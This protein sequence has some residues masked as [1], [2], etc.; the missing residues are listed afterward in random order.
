MFRHKLYLLFLLLLAACGGNDTAPAEGRET[1]TTAVADTADITLVLMPTID[2]LP[3]YKAAREGLFGRQGVKVRLLTAMSQ[4]DCDT[5][6]IGRTRAV[7]LMDSLR[8]AY[9]QRTGARLEVVDTTIAQGWAAVACGQL[10]LKKP[11]QLKLRTIGTARHTAADHCIA[12]LLKM[13]GTQTQDAL[14]PQ[15][16]DIAVRAKM[17]DGDQLN[18]ALLP[19]PYVSAARAKGHDVLW[20]APAKAYAGRLVAAKA[21]TDR[22]GFREDWQK[23]QKAAAEAAR[24][25][26][27][28]GIA[29]ARTT[30]LED[31]RL[32]QAALDSLRLP[33]F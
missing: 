22:K 19:E 6:I 4:W 32:P 5:A 18:A 8:L 29:A 12:T 15:V 1:D 30:L 28:E 10:R 21:V 17:L 26:N 7:G 11:D 9:R 13:N 31:Y 24:R 33:K 16:N 14:L 27:R 25:L 2:C 23:V 3:Y 20:T